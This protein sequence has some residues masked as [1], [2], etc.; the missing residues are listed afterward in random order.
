MINSPLVVP[1]GGRWVPASTAIDSD[2]R[3]HLPG[4]IDRE[5]WDAWNA[6]QD[7]RFFLVRN[8]DGETGER[9][10]CSR[11]SIKSVRNGQPST[12]AVYHEFFTYA[13][14]DRPW[15]GLDGA[16][17]GYTTLTADPRMAR[18]MARFGPDIGR[19]HPYSFGRM[20]GASSSDGDWIAVAL[21]TLEP[22]SEQY[23]RQ[24]EQRINERRPPEPFVL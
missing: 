20:Q 3:L 15:R 5:T 13:C 17:F 14:V 23:A 8:R 18:W 9:Y 24:L 16:L 6:L 21:G 12:E 22:I 4:T 19:A 7:S 2:G 11:C 1:S 10:A